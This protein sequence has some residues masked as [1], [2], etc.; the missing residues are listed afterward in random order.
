[1]TST[2]VLNVCFTILKTENNS[3][4]IFYVQKNVILINRVK[5]GCPKRNPPV[6]VI[7]KRYKN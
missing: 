2:E 1:V 4:I 5:Q 3:H 7:Y 6:C